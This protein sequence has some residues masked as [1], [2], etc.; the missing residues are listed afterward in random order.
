MTMGCIPLTVSFDAPEQAVYFWDFGDGTSSTIQS[1]QHIFS[2]A[3]AFE[4]RLFDENGGTLIG[5]IIVDVFPDPIIT[6]T[7]SQSDDCIPSEVVFSPTTV[8][9]D[10]INIE[11]YT[12]VFGDGNTSNEEAPTHIYT[13]PGTYTVSLS[14][15]T[16]LAE[17]DF[18]QIFPDPVEVFGVNA[19]FAFQ[20]PDL[21]TLPATV[22]FSYT[23][24]DLPGNQ[25]L[26]DFGNGDTDTNQG[27]VITQYTTEGEFTVT[28]QVTASTGCISTRIFNLQ[29]GND[30]FAF[31][32]RDI[33]CINTP[34]QINTLIQCQEYEWILP[35]SFEIDTTIHGQDINTGPFQ[36]IL[37]GMFTE[38]G[39]SM[40]SLF[41]ITE[42]GCELD[43]TITIDVKEPDA[44]FIID[45]AF[46]CDDITPLEFVPEIST[47]PSYIISGIEYSTPGA[48][49]D[50]IICPQRDSFYAHTNMSGLFQMVVIDEFGCVDSA[51]APFTLVKPEACI[52]ALPNNGCAPLE[53]T[54]SNLTQSFYDLTTSTWDLGD[55]TI[56]TT[57]ERDSFV[58][59]YA[60]PGDYYTKMWMTNV[61]GCQDTSAGVWI[62][63]GDAASASVQLD[64]YGLCLSDEVEITLQNESAN[65]DSWSISGVVNSCCPSSLTVQDLNDLE[66]IL[67]L[68]DN[69]CYTDIPIDLTI[70]NIQNTL[71]EIYYEID[72][73]RPFLVEFSQVYPLLPGE[74][75]TWSV[76]NEVISTSE[77]FSYNFDVTGTYDIT[78]VIEN[79]SCGLSTATQ[80]IFITDVIADLILEEEYCLGDP[81]TLDGSSSQ[82]VFEESLNPYSFIVLE[83]TRPLDVDND[84]L[85]SGADIPGVFTAVLTV[86]DAN[87]CTDT[88]SAEY[89]VHNINADFSLPLDS[90]CVDGLYPLTNLSISDTTIIEYAWNIDISDESDPVITYDDIDHLLYEDSIITIDL[91]I[92]DANGCRDLMSHTY[93]VFPFTAD[94]QFSE[95]QGICLG[96]SITFEA[97][98]NL[99]GGTYSADWQFSNGT[100]FNGQ[101]QTIQFDEVGLIDIDLML[102]HHI[103]QCPASD[104]S[105][106]DVAAYPVAAFTTSIDTVDVICHPAVIEFFDESTFEGLHTHNW[107]MSGSPVN[108]NPNPTFTFDKGD[109]TATLF[110]SHPY[111]C[112]DTTAIDFT[113]IGPE[114]LLT[115]L[116]DTLCAGEDLDASLSGLVDVNQITWD[117]GDGTLVE[118]DE[119]I[120]HVY[121]SPDLTASTVIKAILRSDDNGC[122]TILEH[123]IV[124]GAVPIEIGVEIENGNCTNTVD[125]LSSGEIADIF[126]W[127]YGD[128]SIGNGNPVTHSYTESGEFNIL[129]EAIDAE[130]QCRSTANVT[131]N[132]EL[133]D[134]TFDV[135]NMFTPNGD[136]T[137]DFFNFVSNGVDNED[138]T[139]N[140]FKVYNRWGNLI[141]DN[142]QPDIG[143]NGRIDGELA[144]SEVYG[145]YIE[146]DIADCGTLGKKGNVTLVR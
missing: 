131:I 121:N 128:G 80:T 113:L 51:S 112:A 132:L 57:T 2:S 125:F 93:P 66:G 35:S 39:E 143:W 47:Y 116:D 127:E 115:V 6:T 26:W 107:S 70:E 90:I 124:I 16:D 49:F 76:Q 59:I 45:P 7:Y 21:C 34:V 138:I 79:E 130:T 145:Y 117:L 91:S 58:H 19:N 120:S 4:I 27:P 8:I 25:Y 54:F 15:E 137:N 133:E 119:M 1:P 18:V 9:D 109:Q 60:E 46:S 30:A 63:V 106:V 65:I 96:D 37:Q 144:P 32:P 122:E 83:D 24:D 28:L 42:S 114:G 50:T 17:C 82:D 126:N 61:E 129:L 141:Y 103:Y 36:S 85:M 13:D 100:S 111:G 81:I 95:A 97:L 89:V 94:I 10:R 140:A 5:S 78:V 44:E 56:V 68:E 55:G 88:A 139:V 38:S 75:I 29:T 87:G 118:D 92:L 41:C 43:T 74:T 142:A 67:T 71:A 84:T 3:G 48:V 22:V 104:V 146:L 102:T 73:G 77:A 64:P 12:W 53:V 136:S 14:I 69:G 101:I 31:D 72:C 40:I 123:P 134:S 11:S 98:S 23:G 52:G 20:S 105:V 33:E 110:L 86:T 99:E 108:N 62:H 135:P